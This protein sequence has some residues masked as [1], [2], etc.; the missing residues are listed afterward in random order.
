MQHILRLIA[1]LNLAMLQ[2]HHTR[3]GKPHSS[4]TLSPP[5]ASDWL[6]AKDQLCS[7][8]AQ[9]TVGTPLYRCH[10]NAAPCTLNR[11]SEIARATNKVMLRVIR[12]KTLTSRRNFLSGRPKYS[13]HLQVL[14]GRNFTVFSLQKRC[15]SGFW[16]CSDKKTNIL[17]R[18]WFT[19][20]SSRSDV[21]T[22][23]YRSVVLFGC[24]IVTSLRVQHNSSAVAAYM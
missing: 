12:R 7:P 21:C 20:S 23:V 19:S 4:L 15:G 22:A 5:A 3:N 11:A 6:E 10:S 9:H 14:R 24:F 17:S 16:G 18:Y 1:C 8:A 13:L 2:S